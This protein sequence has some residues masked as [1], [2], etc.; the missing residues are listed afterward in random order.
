[1]E[2]LFKNRRA[3]YLGSA[4]FIQVKRGAYWRI[5]TAKPFPSGST[6]KSAE[7]D[8]DDLASSFND[9]FNPHQTR[10]MSSG[11]QSSLS[12]M[13]VPGGA[14]PKQLEN[15]APVQ[16]ALAQGAGEQVT[17]PTLPPQEGH[18]PLFV[19][20]APTQQGNN[21]QQGG[22]TKEQENIVQRI[23][24]CD[25]DKWYDILDVADNCSTEEANKQYKKLALLLHPDQNR[26]PG[27]HEAFIS[28]Y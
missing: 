9:K 6:N 4:Y 25:M 12:S 11:G 27:A 26:H 16:N 23:L 5:S 18:K 2:Y 17:Y 8:V 21:S 13:A 19:P 24:D 22:F 15:S 3:V 7:I 10:E 28:K 20:A 14:A 1:M